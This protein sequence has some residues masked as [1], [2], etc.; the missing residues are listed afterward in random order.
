[1]FK[2][3]ASLAAIYPRL[4]RQAIEGLSCQDVMRFFNKDARRGSGQVTSSYQK[5]VQGVRLKQQLGSNWIKMYDK[6]GRVLRVETTTINDPHSL[7]VFR[8]TLEKPEQDL[9]WRPMAKAVADIARRVA[10]SRQANQRYRAAL[11]P[12]G[13]AVQTAAVLDAVAEAVGPKPK[14]CG[15][16]GGGPRGCGLLAAVMDG[17]HLM[18]A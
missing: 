12:V 4:C 2:D 11:A 10:V 6:A 3:P 9:K 17:R 14:R 7:R 1:M 8:G 16:C 5:R 13:Q 15:D 18:T